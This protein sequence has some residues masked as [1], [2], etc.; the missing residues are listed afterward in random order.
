MH[1]RRA[2]FAFCLSTLTAACEPS[3]EVGSG[4]A[5]TG[6]AS[7]GG[8]A[9]GA[10]PAGGAAGA[11]ETGGAGGGACTVNEVPL[12]VSSYDGV[13]ERF[14]VPV[15]RDGADALLF[16]DTGSALT[17]LQLEDGPDYLP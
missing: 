11:G 12:V 17:F 8:G 15:R 14:W 7:A 5:D 3:V 10:A 6:G 1:L 9:G 13:P 4:G 16:F 2:L